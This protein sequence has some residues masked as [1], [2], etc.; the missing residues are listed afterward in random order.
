MSSTKDYERDLAELEAAQAAG[1]AE[2]PQIVPDV[3]GSMKAAAGLRELPWIEGKPSAAQK[4]KIVEALARGASY[5]DVAA[6]TNITTVTL[7]KWVDSHQ[8]HEIQ[9][10]KEIRDAMAAQRYFTKQGCTYGSPAREL[11]RGEV[12]SLQGQLNDAKCISV[13]LFKKV[14][15]GASTYRDDVWGK[16]FI[17]QAHAYSY[18]REQERLRRAQTE[19]ER[20]RILAATDKQVEAELGIDRLQSV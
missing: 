11:A 9:P 2:D 13:G 14:P 10:R 15:D 5:E 12:F 3:L 18:R 8:P 17:D 20:Q 1:E 6:A 7:R 19:Q 16:E 4:A